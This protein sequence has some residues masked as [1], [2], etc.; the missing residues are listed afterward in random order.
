MAAPVTCHWAPVFTASKDPEG[1][2]R[3]PCDQ[4]PQW[5]SEQ[6]VSGM[7]AQMD[8]SL[9][10]QM[11]WPE[12]CSTSA[13]GTS[14]PF[15]H[16]SPM[17][18]M[19]RTLA[20]RRQCG[21]CS[22]PCHL[23]PACLSLLVPSLLIPGGCPLAS[24]VGTYRLTLTT[25]GL[26]LPHVCANRTE[27]SWLISLTPW[28]RTLVNLQLQTQACRLQLPGLPPKEESSWFLF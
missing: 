6:S 5:G 7:V 25:E 20:P 28:H 15:G 4:S 8:C 13:L 22:H 21:S 17:N 14:P 9:W 24:V 19:W 3:V 18:G 11:R 2:G 26:L 23:R 1:G 12:G 10:G 27:S 16:N